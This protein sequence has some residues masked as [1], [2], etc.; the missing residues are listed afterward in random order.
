MIDFLN[1]KELLKKKSDTEYNG[2]ELKHLL[3]NLFPLITNEENKR[4]DYENLY[5]LID[6]IVDLQVQK[7]IPILTI[8]LGT[9][10]NIDQNGFAFYIE[11]LTEKAKHNK[12]N[13]TIFGRWYDL[14]GDIVEALKVLNNSTKDFEDFFL[15]I[16][17]NYDS[18]QE[19]ADACRVIIR[20]IYDE[21]MDFDSITPEILKE[22]IYSSYFISPNLIIEPL[23]NFN[24]TFLWDSVGAKIKF[25]N[26]EIQ[27][28]TKEDIEK[29]F[30]DY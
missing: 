27:K 16:C 24:G 7:K 6:N 30:S 11:R 8:S 28:I 20:K 13:T 29:A 9:K 3:V 10:E 22:N 26:K 19:I 2:K 23:D 25:L 18:H 12:I 17:I 4:K 15:N 1:L 21:K 5:N 14:P